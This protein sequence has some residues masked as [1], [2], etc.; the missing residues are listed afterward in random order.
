MPGIAGIVSH[1]S[2]LD[3]KSAVER[4]IAA[5]VHEPFYRSGSVAVERLGAHAGWVA[6][7]GSFSDCMP[8]WNETRDICL[9]FSG[10]H[11]PDGDT[12]PTLKRKGHVIGQD[13]ATALVHLYEESPQDFLSKL[14]GYFVGAIFDIRKNTVTIFNDRYGL[15]RLYVH[16]SKT[17]FYFASEAKSILKVRP[18]LR[19]ISPQGLGEFFACGSVLQN[20]SLFP[21]VSVLPPGSVWTIAGDGTVRKEKYFDRNEWE[22]QDPISPE[23]YYDRLKALL[24][25]ILPRYFRDLT[26]GRAAM[27]LTGGL[28]GRIVMAWAKPAPGTLP[29]YSHRGI[30]NQCADARIARKVATI[31]GQS[32]RD[33]TVG[34]E[35]LKQFPKLAAHTV[36]VTDGCMDVGGAAGLYANRVARNEIATMR[37]TGNYGGEILRG[38]VMLGPA[39][40]RNRYFAPELASHIDQGLQ[41]LA[42]ERK[43]VPRLSYIAFKQ[44]PW[45]HYARFAMENSQVAVR[46]PYLDNDLVKL[47]YLAPSDLD[48]NFKIAERLIADGN[49][50]LASF[51]T[52]RGPLGRRGPV[53]KL[54]EK[55]QEL[56]FKADYAFDYGMPN[57]LVR[58][59]NAFKFL[60]LERLFLGR[61][62]YNHFRYFYRT[63]LAPYVREIL[64]DRRT[65]GRSLFNPKA[66][67]SIVIGHTTGQANYTVEIHA[68]L[69]AELMQRQLIE[70]N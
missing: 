24:P 63:S 2:Y 21:G 9:L 56:T 59:D 64:L 16:E 5:M 62:K 58:F 48:A 10:E 13:N 25:Q 46:S 22:S 18:E 60:H 20:R 70:N 17:G 47:A 29:C 3:N 11:F 39:K 54:A 8:V 35:F 40:L 36:Y 1:S 23:D 43:N 65:L 68:L 45:H 44:T 37:M 55:W 66:V 28:D 61:H 34:E 52:D 50:A 26:P 14:N 49:P 51:P 30:F 42:N 6:H 7:E 27:S 15:G 69:T 57:S 38:T 31:C 32:H 41:T 19:E 12:L 4:M 33:V 67:E 53:G